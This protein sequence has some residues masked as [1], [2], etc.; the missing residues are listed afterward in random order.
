MGFKCAPQ[1]LG[2]TIGEPPTKTNSKTGKKYKNRHRANGAAIAKEM[3]DER[4][5]RSETLDR[6]RSHLNKYEGFTSGEDCWAD[7]LND[8]AEYKMPVKL[9][10]GQ[11][12]YRKLGGRQL[13]EL[14]PGWSII[15]NPPPEMTVGWT[16]DDYDRFDADGMEVLAEICPIFKAKNHKGKA[17]H[18][19]EG[20]EDINGEFGRHTHWIGNCWD[21]EGRYCGS[22]INGLLYDEI[23]RRFPELMRVKGWDLDDLDVTDWDRLKTDDDYR[24]EREEKRRSKGRSV[25]KVIADELHAA[26]IETA[27]ERHAARELRAEVDELEQRAGTILTDAMDTARTVT[28]DARMDVRTTR[29]EADDYAYHTRRKANRDAQEII[30]EA[31]EDAQAIREEA[32]QIK[33]QAERDA[34]AMREQVA[35]M[36]RERD[37]AQADRDAA[38]QDAYTWA[39]KANKLQT[40]HK[41]LQT[42]LQGDLRAWD[43]QEA[44][45]GA[46]ALLDALGATVRP[47]IAKAAQ[48]AAQVDMVPPSVTPGPVAGSVMAEMLRRA[49]AMGRRHAERDA[50]RNS[51]S[52]PGA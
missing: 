39:V 36:R 19:D 9:K 50:G 41:S 47:I 34:Q 16:D 23:N 26:K 52:Y 4:A 43:A 28:A 32:H 8:V 17:I 24:A 35:A 48:K 10:N 45:R 11:T 30:D 12:A 40:A 37:E 51:P 2:L 15:L 14:V 31:E 21:D 22:M 13:E 25:N 38:H 44:R 5:S 49:E 1:L 46:V 27:M 7:M 18:R 29:R 33:A 3:F 20:R 42:A 6:R